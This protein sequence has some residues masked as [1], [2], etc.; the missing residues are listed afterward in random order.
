MVARKQRRPRQFPGRRTPWRKR[1]VEHQ[2]NALTC[3][4][5]ERP[6]L[7][8]SFA[9]E[10]IAADLK[11]AD[12]LGAPRELVSVLNRTLPEKMNARLAA[13]LDDAMTKSLRTGEVF[14]TLNGDWVASG[15]FVSAGDAR[16]LEEGAGLADFQTRVERA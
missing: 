12:L 8:I 14:V 16:A 6:A 13:N 3:D 7:S 9:T 15:Q 1:R 5:E 2:V 10:A 11:I 4:V